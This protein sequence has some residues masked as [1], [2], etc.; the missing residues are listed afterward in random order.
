MSLSNYICQA[1]GRDYTYH[2]EC[3]DTDLENGMPCPS[4]DCPSHDEQA[5]A[6]AKGE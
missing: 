4:D 3:G 5:F 1:C 6:Q 2:K